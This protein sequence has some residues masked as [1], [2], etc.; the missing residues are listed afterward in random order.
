MPATMMVYCRRSFSSIGVSCLVK[1]SL[2]VACTLALADR[3][4][5]D[6]TIKGKEMRSIGVF[7]G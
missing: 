3:V 7:G 2:E 6:A 1:F 5:L 4:Y